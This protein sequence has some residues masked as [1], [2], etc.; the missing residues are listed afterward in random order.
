M[1]TCPRLTA[2]AHGYYSPPACENDVELDQRMICTP[3]CD[4]GYNLIDE[5][6]SECLINGSWSYTPAG[7]FCESMFHLY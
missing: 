5:H 3:G 4:T 6:E 1:I 2:D 7:P